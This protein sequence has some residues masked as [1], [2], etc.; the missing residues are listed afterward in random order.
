MRT[1]RIASF[2]FVLL[3]LAPVVSAEGVKNPFYTGWAKFAVGSSATLTARLSF[4]GHVCNLK[5]INTLAGKDDDHVS[6]DVVQVTDIPGAPRKT[7]SH[8]VDSAA[9]LDKRNV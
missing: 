6:I 7:E 1:S 5:M 4:E 9:A 2:A 3:L 8:R